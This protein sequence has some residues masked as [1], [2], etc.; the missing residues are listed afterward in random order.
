MRKLAL[1][2]TALLVLT[3]FEF[4]NYRSELAKGPYGI[5]PRVDFLAIAGSGD[6]CTNQGC[7]ADN[8]CSDL[9]GKT[10]STG[11]GGNSCTQT[12]CSQ[13]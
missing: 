4:A 3:S 6:G 5:T 13:L 1:L 8:G 10:C 9:T 2:T 7:R 11:E 12:N